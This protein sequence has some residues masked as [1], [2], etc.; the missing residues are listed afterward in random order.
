[1]LYVEDE[2]KIR[3]AYMRLLKN[4]FQ[5]VWTAENGEEALELYHQNGPEIIIADILM[6][7]IDGLQL[8]EHIR[9][10][11][12]D[13]RVILLTAHSEKEKLLKAAELHISK[14]LIKP[15]K[16]KELLQAIELAGKQ[17]EKIKGE[18]LGF[19]NGCIFRVRSKRLL[20]QNHEVELTKNESI[21]LSILASDPEY[22]FSIEEISTLFYIRY[23]K[24]LSSNAVKALIK[25][26]RKKIPGNFIE[27]RFGYGYRLLL[28]AVLTPF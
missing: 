12:F 2:R 28:S 11:D 26:L 20:C 8:I 14:Y 19:S 1:M 25:R 9:K 17:L 27:N 3:Q 24:D 18:I 21:F 7:K 5:H 22:Y 13:T 4:Y 23:D 6:P 15:V 16:K 10:N